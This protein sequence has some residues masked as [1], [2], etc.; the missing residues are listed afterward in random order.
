MRSAK[1]QSLDA[2]IRQI[3]Q[4]IL[5]TYDLEGGANHVDDSNLPSVAEVESF[6]KKAMRLLFP[7]FYKIDNV[8]SGNIG[9]W[10]GFLLD[11]LFKDLLHL[12]LHSTQ[13][14]SVEGGAQ[15]E[16]RAETL[17]LE[18][19][20]EIPKIRTLLKADVV[21]AFDGDPAA[22]SYE[23]VIMCY[24][25]IQA[26][27]MHRL[28]HELYLRDIP[29][30]SRMISEY[31]HARTGI[32]IHPGARIGKSFFIDHGTG[33]VI[34]ET[35]RIGDHVKIYQMVTLGA[36]SFSKDDRGKLI[37]GLIRHPTIEDHVILYAG[38]TIL[39][40]KTIIGKGSV[41]GGNVW[42]TESVEPGT[43]ITFDVHRQEYRRERKKA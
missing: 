32:D 39:G 35:C 28:A 18:I 29:L 9:N 34:G 10:S 16:E 41:I 3:H 13:L 27:A 4:K 22:K 24:P 21:A 8:H 7:G 43:V 37:K 17:A 11:D 12:I 14:V 33:V 42:I 31:A 2:Q 5:Q 25:A 1:K 40:G 36:L 26:I 30:I 20:A 38:C 15:N 19:L 6:V 23:E